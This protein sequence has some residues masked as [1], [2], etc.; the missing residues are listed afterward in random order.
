M[1]HVLL[2][3]ALLAFAGCD[4]SPN[5][6][7]IQQMDAQRF[8]ADMR[9]QLHRS[10]EAAQRAIMAD[11]DESASAFAAEAEQANAALEA[12][13]AAIEPIVAQIGSQDEVRLVQDT[14]T[15]FGRLQE[16]DGTLLALAVENTNVKAQRLSFGPAREAADALRSH[17]EGAVRAAPPAQALARSCS[18]RACSSACARSRRSR[19][20]TSLRRTTP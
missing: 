4:R 2:A 3:L 12:D 6:A 20:R 11:T 7:L 8:A 17:L 13:L 15:A 5:V 18:R 10:A 16:L 19:R 14:R 1:T 9:V